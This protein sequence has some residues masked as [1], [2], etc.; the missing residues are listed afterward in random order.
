[1]LCKK[2]YTS[3]LGSVLHYLFFVQIC[4]DAGKDVEESDMH[5]WVETTAGLY[6]HTPCGGNDL[7]VR[8]QC[9][10]H[11]PLFEQDSNN[12]IDFSSFRTFNKCP[13]W[14]SF[15]T[16]LLGINLQCSDPQPHG[17]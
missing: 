7:P 15:Y 3:L 12:H 10:L 8:G 5:S 2:I 6:K 14:Q 17:I 13:A 1:M 11:I 4:K 16:H 9:L